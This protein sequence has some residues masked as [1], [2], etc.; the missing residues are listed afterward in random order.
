MSAPR[1]LRVFRR[2]PAAVA[3]L[4]VM[5]VWPRQAAAQVWIG[6]DGPRRG[7]VTISGGV[8]SFGGFDLGTRNAEETRNINTGSGPFALFAVDSRVARAPGAQLR[9][10][11][12]LSPAISIETGLQYGRPKLSSRLSGDA[13]QAPD[14]TAVETVTRYLVDGSVLFHLTPLAFAGHRGMPFFGVGGGYLREL[15]DQN[16]LVETGREY[17]AIGGLELWFGRRSPRFGVRADVGASMRD[18]GADF[19][20]GRRTVPTAGVSLVYLF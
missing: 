17:H 4:L 20:S 6:S 9:A 7:S 12:Y 16:E 1:S 3:V 11:V 2:W 8:V 10:G 13:E 15:H 5:A 19:R 14:V 18:G